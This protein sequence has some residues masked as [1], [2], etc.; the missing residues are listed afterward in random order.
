MSQVITN[1]LILNSEAKIA[2]FIVENSELFG[3]LK[4]TQIASILNISPETLSR[5]LGKFKKN[6]LIQTDDTHQV[7]ILKLADL[8]QLYNYST[9]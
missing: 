6:N 8:N 7:I 4:N 1:E 9:T 2:K 3:Q 5:A